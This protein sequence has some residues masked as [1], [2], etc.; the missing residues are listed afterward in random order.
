MNDVEKAEAVI[1]DLEQKRTKLIDHGRNIADERA[2]I[3]YE[4]HAGGDAKARVKLDKLNIDF[5]LHA[6]E[7]ESIDAALKTAGER[8][9]QAQRDEASAEDRAAAAQAKSKYK[10]LAA[11]G[12]RMDEH[13]LALSM[14]AGE[15][16]GLVNELHALGCPMPTG[17][18]FQ[19]YMSIATST[20]IMSLPWSRNFDHRFLSPNE[21]RKF[22]PLLSGW[23]NAVLPALEARLGNGVAKQTTK[24]PETEAA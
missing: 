11:L 9:A 1:A 20:A 14:A 4:V 12:A 2:A 21:K 22:G 3:G 16:A 18:Q 6:G 13:A 7:V 5:A 19:T 15:A 8:L 24:Q 17:A 23:S 10:R